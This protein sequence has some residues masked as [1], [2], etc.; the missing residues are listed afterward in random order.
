VK[1]EASAPL[2]PLVR[3]KKE[4]GVVPPSMKKACR[5][6]ED[7]AHQLQYQAPD[8]SDE[9]LGQRAAE[10]ASV[11]EVQPGTLKFT[12]AGPGRTRRRPRQSAHLEDE[13]AGPS[14]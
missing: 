13:D 10:R 5:L 9:F 7:A 11:N 3:V 8:D 2:T 14:Q 1:K 6:A 12:L 4:A